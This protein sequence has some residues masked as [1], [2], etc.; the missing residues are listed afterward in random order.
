MSSLAP[1]SRTAPVNVLP[2]LKETKF[3]T[4][5]EQHNS[6]EQSPSWEANRFLVSQEIP[7]ILWIPNFRWRINKSPPPVPIMSQ[8]SSVHTPIP[9]RED[10][11]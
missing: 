3:R 2:V 5:A 4:F 11:F 10:P 6:T 8:I 9:I 7:Q 1:C